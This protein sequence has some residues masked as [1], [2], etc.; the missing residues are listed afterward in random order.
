MDASA[1]ETIKPAAPAQNPNLIGHQLELLQHHFPQLRSRAAAAS[2]I[3]IAQGLGVIA[4]QQQQHH[5]ELIAVKNT[6]KTNPVDK[7]LRTNKLR[8]LL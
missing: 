8:R 5:D 7:L 4:T 1:L 6:V 3:L 2:H